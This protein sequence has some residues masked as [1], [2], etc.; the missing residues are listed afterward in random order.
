MPRGDGTGPAGIGPLT[1]RGAGFCNGFNVPGYANPGAGFGYGLG[2]GRGG[3]GRGMGRGFRGWSM[4]QPGW[5]TGRY[6]PQAQVNP[7]PEL[8]KRYLTLQM[9]ELSA[10]LEAVKK[11]LAEIES[12]N[13]TEKK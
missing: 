8:E 3:M 1:G 13:P 10:E 7:D 5:N 11:R 2:R 6:L 12:P 9:D 4:A